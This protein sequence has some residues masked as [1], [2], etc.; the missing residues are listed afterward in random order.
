MESRKPSAEQETSEIHKSM[1][2]LF[3]CA[4]VVIDKPQDSLFSAS[5]STATMRVL[6]GQGRLS[7]PPRSTSAACRVASSK[8]CSSSRKQ[9]MQKSLR[10]RK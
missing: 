2:E 1:K 3:S 9:N 8:H 10:K 7:K 4:L 6:T 5:A